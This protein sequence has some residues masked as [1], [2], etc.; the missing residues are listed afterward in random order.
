MK[1]KTAIKIYIHQYDVVNFL[2]SVASRFLFIHKM[3]KQDGKMSAHIRQ[4]LIISKLFSHPLI[5]SNFLENCGKNDSRFWEAKIKLL[6]VITSWNVFMFLFS[7]IQ[8][9]SSIDP[10]NS[11]I[12]ERM[13]TEHKDS[14]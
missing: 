12:R 2:S 4:V 8:L 10:M 11:M 1:I 7:H 5:N 13:R 14:E 6:N 3:N 9:I